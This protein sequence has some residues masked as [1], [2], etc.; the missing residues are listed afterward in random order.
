MD[1]RNACYW[2]G[3]S[4]VKRERYLILRPLQRKGG[5]SQQ[6][7][8]ADNSK[9]TELFHDR[10]PTPKAHSKT[11]KGT[12]GPFEMCLPPNDASNLPGAGSFLLLEKSNRGR[13]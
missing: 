4:A 1:A 9:H 5:H 2:P 11:H 13:R 10:S 7:G 3:I 12:N 6:G 8:T